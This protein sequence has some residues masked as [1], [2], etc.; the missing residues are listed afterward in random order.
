M[1]RFL[2]VLMIAALGVFL[3]AG[4][5]MAMGLDFGVVFP[6]PSPPA[7][8]SYAGGAAPLM[9]IEIEVDNVGGLDTPL[10]NGV[11]LDLSN[12][13]LNFTTGANTGLWTWG[14]G[15]ASSIE[16]VGGVPA[17]GLG[18][19]TVLMTGS[20]GSAFVARLSNN[21]KLTG[22]NFIDIKDPTLLEFF[23]LPTVDPNG[24]PFSYVG[25]FNLSFNAEQNTVGEAF[26]S[27]SVLSGDVP[28]EVPEPGTLLLI[29]TGLLGLAGLGRRKLRKK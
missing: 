20:F 7:S 29:G 14:G 16:I 23:G 9:G 8:I 26:T 2:S 24:D 28:N 19:D 22:G 11:V 21:L 6:T 17:L 13:T 27:I 3:V 25:G 10:N 18:D 4:S 5:A 15:A 1:K 12:A